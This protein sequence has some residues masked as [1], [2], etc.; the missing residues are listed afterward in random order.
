MVFPPYIARRLT[1][2]RY[3]G[4]QE[5]HTRGLTLAGWPSGHRARSATIISL[6]HPITF[7]I[8]SCPYLSIQRIVTAVS[9]DPI[10]PNLN[11][12]IHTEISGLRR[13]ERRDHPYTM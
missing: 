1:H 6:E 9:S 10:S 2:Y 12:M 5:Q 8:L 4:F 3:R 7:L 11:F 13:R